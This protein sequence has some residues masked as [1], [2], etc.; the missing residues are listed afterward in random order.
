MEGQYDEGKFSNSK[1]SNLSSFDNPIKS[2]LDTLLYFKCILLCLTCKTVPII[3]PYDSDFQRAFVLCKCDEE[4]KKMSY[5]EILEEFLLKEEGNNALDEYIKCFNHEEVFEYYC[6]N[7]EIHLCEKCY[8]SHKCQIKYVL[9]FQNLKYEIEEKINYINKVFSNLDESFILV[10]NIIYILLQQY[11]KYP[12]YNINKSLNNFFW[13]F[14]IIEEEKSPNKDNNQILISSKVLDFSHSQINTFGF[15][16][17]KE[18]SNLKELKLENN[19]LNN[20]QIPIFKILKCKNLEILN[21][22]LNHFTDYLLLTVIENFPN[23]I[24]LDLNTNRLYENVEALKNK[25]FPYYSIKKLNLS[26][27]VFSNDTI[28]FISS[29]LF[30]NLKDLNLSS[31]DLN[32]LSFIRHINFENEKNSIEK[33]KLYNNEISIDKIKDEDIEYLNTI[34]LNL[35]LVILEKDYPIEYKT[36]KYLRFKIICFDKEKITNFLLDKYVEKENKNRTKILPD[37]Q[38]FYNS[39]I[40]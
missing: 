13:S 16:K 33:L 4:G 26:N 15:L 12:N 34:Y 30:K 17:N 40:E 39:K 6:E 38:I 2:I 36:K 1:Y 28:N 25:T 19:K 11:N 32:S 9:N 8:L 29:L 21:L 20:S 24:N 35:K 5:E 3:K 27:G 23:L 14:F 7:H 37:Y 18:L 22:A 31:N 10:K